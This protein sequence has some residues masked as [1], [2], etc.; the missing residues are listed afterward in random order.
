[1]SPELSCN[2]PRWGRERELIAL[3]VVLVSCE[4]C[5]AL[6]HD[7]THLSAVCD[8]GATIFDAHVVWS[9]TAVWS[10]EHRIFINIAI[11]HTM[12]SLNVICIHVIDR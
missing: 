9:W 4:C 7:A 12:L 5:V 1:M 8:C 3:L 2:Q 11:T 10:A 6:P